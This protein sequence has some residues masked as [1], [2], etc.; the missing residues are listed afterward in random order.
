VTAQP[1]KKKRKLRTPAERITDL[2]T[3]FF[4]KG[5]LAKLDVPDD[6]LLAGVRAAVEYASEGT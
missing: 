5:Q 6:E 4:S 2:L 1:V 3:T